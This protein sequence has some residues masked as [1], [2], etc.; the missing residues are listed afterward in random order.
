MVTRIVIT[1]NDYDWPPYTQ[2]YVAIYLLKILDNEVWIQ[3][4]PALI[5]SKPPQSLLHTL[6]AKIFAG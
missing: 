4:N 6:Q 1:T 5:K 3:L 2:K